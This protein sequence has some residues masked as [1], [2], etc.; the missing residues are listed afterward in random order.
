MDD[1]MKRLVGKLWDDVANES[2]EV[3][4]FTEAVSNRMDKVL[5][6]A[7]IAIIKDRQYNHQGDE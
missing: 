3:M 4:K 6:K 2:E 1:K 7:A 5:S